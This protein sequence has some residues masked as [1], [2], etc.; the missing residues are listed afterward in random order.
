MYSESWS[1]K[2]ATIVVMKGCPATTASTLRSL[3]TC[4]TCLSR[5]T[6][7]WPLAAVDSWRGRRHTVHLAQDLER[8][9]PVQF[10]ALG[11]LEPYEPDT[12]KGSWRAVSMPAGGEVQKPAYRCPMS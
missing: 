3:R 6:G 11:I 2:L 9:D 1:W 8:E 12:R 4:S 10:A 5:I 7:T